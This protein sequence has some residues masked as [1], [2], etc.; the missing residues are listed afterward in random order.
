MKSIIGSPFHVACIAAVA[1]TSGCLQAQTASAPDPAEGNWLG[2][3][4]DANNG[5]VMCLEIVRGADG[6]LQAYYSLEQLNLYHYPMD[7]FKVADGHYTATGGIDLR[8]KDG[9][10]TGTGASKRELVLERADKPLTD[11]P[12]PTDLPKGPGPRWRAK[13]GGA[14]YAP[15]T[16]RDGYAYVGT[17]SGH[18]SAVRLADGTVAWHFPAGRPIFGGALATDDA[19]YFACDNG[20]L[21]RLAR[22]DGKEIW[23]YDLGGERTP[24]LLPDP[25][26]QRPDGFDSTAPTPVLVDGVLYIGSADGSFHAVRAETGVRV[27]RFESK[28]QIRTTAAVSGPNIIFSTHGGLIQTVERANGKEVWKFD[29]QAA[30]VT[31]P[32]LIGGHLI[33]GAR[34]SLLYGMDPASGAIQWKLSFWGSWVESAATD[35]GDGLAYI[36]S[37]DLRRITCFDPKDG[38]IVW[39][40]DFFG[41]PWGKPVLS[42]KYLY[43]G[44]SALTPYLM[45]EEGGVVALDRQ[46]GKLAWRWP[47][48]NPPGTYSYGFAASPVLADGLLLMGASDGTLYAFP[49]D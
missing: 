41:D 29:T 35:G 45:R 2:R 32:A 18:L 38:R 48:P 31:A 43:D 22:A 10:L 17:T 36:G 40:T 4:G 46:T 47:L 28:G 49:A 1:L 44:T 26:E 33:I 23:R 37:S 30:G 15:A 3:T 19:L 12:I 14:I 8:L 11:P 39:R 5:S 21:Y 34:N 42:A 20:Y 16:V 6:Q 13:L 9:K 27:W 25:N 7:D 24:R